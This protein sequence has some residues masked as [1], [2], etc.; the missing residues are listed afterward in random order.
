MW[1]GWGVYDYFLYTGEEEAERLF[2]EAVRTLHNN[3]HRFDVIFW[4]LYEQSGTRIKML[5]SPFYHSLHIVQLKV[6]HRLTEDPVF[7]QV[8]DRWDSY[9]RDPVKRNAA[10][11]YKAIF[12]L[13]YY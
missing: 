12:K 4:S 8:A 11:A 10:L 3:L 13:L 9:R 5:A 6:M 1:A 7:K 2:R